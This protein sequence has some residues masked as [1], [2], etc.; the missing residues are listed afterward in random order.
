MSLID[1]ISSIVD[2][3]TL[4]GLPV[5]VA[6]VVNYNNRTQRQNG[7]ALV[8]PQDK[9]LVAA[10]GNQVPDDFVRYLL[11]SKRLLGSMSYRQ[12]ALPFT[13]AIQQYVDSSDYLGHTFGLG[14]D[15]MDTYRTAASMGQAY[16]P[17]DTDLLKIAAMH[18]SR[19]GPGSVYAAGRAIA[20]HLKDLPPAAVVLPAIPDSSDIS[21]ETLDNLNGLVEQISAA[22]PDSLIEQPTYPPL[23]ANYGRVGI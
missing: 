17:V 1:T 2:G 9:E 12:G 13:E 6:N 22:F 19:K 16:D 4:G 5:A 8:F 15:I 3:E 21:P 10:L 20:D 7:Q 14:D 23:A 11:R 18:E